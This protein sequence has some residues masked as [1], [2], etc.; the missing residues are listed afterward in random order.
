MS[1]ARQ[2]TST[3]R[4]GLD[5]DGFTGKRALA[6]A[7]GSGL[8]VLA[9]LACRAALQPEPIPDLATVPGAR[10]ELVEAPAA[11]SRPGSELG[12]SSSA[13]GEWR[14]PRVRLAGPLAGRSA[15]WGGWAERRCLTLML[16]EQGASVQ[17]NVEFDTDYGRFPGRVDPARS[18]VHR[19]GDV[20]CFELGLERLD[21][22][23]FLERWRGELPLR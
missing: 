11:C 15:E 9:V 13:P 17:A 14:E 3:Q 12:V 19:H 22:S 10:V 7:L 5:P 4:S 18:S 8:G 6:V 20:L 16:D 2:E 21:G 23:G 1:P